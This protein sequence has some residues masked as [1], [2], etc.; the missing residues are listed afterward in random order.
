MYW[1]ARMSLQSNRPHVTS[2]TKKQISSFVLCW[3]VFVW[4][5]VCPK[6]FF[7]SSFHFFILFFFFLILQERKSPATGKTKLMINKWNGSSFGCSA[8]GLDGKLRRWRGRKICEAP[9]DEKI[10]TATLFAELW[11]FS[12]ADGNKWVWKRKKSWWFHAI[13]FFFLRKLLFD[14]IL[15]SLNQLE[16]DGEQQDIKQNREREREREK[17]WRKIPFTDRKLQSF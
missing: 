7:F 12:Q 15:F 9:M 13:L 6:L 3:F 16:S 14:L 5:F 10:Q 4:R 11:H 8:S 2:W 1:I 17:S